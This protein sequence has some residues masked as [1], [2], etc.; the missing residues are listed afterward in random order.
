MWYLYPFLYLLME[1][2]LTRSSGIFGY[3]NYSTEKDRRY[4]LN[5]LLNGERLSGYFSYDVTSLIF[6]CERSQ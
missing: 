4:I 2:I 1:I 5:V 3:V 6:Y